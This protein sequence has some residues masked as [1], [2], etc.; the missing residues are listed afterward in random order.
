M[1]N[2]LSLWKKIESVKVFTCFTMHDAQKWNRGVPWGHISPYALRSVL[3]SES[4]FNQS[5]LLGLVCVNSGYLKF[6]SKNSGSHT[7]T[8]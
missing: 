4:P 8:I 3:V 1:Q 6:S 2:Y 5:V 7:E